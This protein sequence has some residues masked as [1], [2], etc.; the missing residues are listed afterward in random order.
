MALKQVDRL[1]P[2]SG[3][4][5]RE[6]LPQL[7]ASAGGENREKDEGPANDA[8]Q[9]NLACLV[10]GDSTQG[11]ASSILATTTRMEIMRPHCQVRSIPGDQSAPRRWAARTSVVALIALTTLLGACRDSVGSVGPRAWIVFVRGPSYDTIFVANPGSG[12]IEQ[13]IPLPIRAFSFR[14]SPAGDRLAIVSGGGLWVMQ[15]DGS[16]ATQLASNVQNIAWSPDGARIAYVAGPP[17]PELHIVGVDGSG[18]ITVPGAVP[19]GLAGL[20]WSPDGERIAFE[21]LLHL[22]GHGETTTVYVINTDGTGLRDIDAS[23]PGPDS[24]AAHEP[25]WSPDGRLIVLSRHILYNA[26]DEEWNLWITDLAK[27]DG[28]RITTGGTTDVRASWSPNGDQ[29]A[30]L[31]AHDNSNDV[32]VVRY[33]GT[34]LRRITDT[35]EFEEEP[36]FWRRP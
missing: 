11:R 16:G 14:F 23:L 5:I 8:R 15:S 24:R 25:A 19:G 12:Q 13:R 10:P 36:Q 28:W 3:S 26:L 4:V 6:R 29:I 22:P 30:F 9:P 20:A 7:R 34:G 1:E 18:D 27:G 31:R 21:G 33:D 17:T 2:K 32:Y 35:P